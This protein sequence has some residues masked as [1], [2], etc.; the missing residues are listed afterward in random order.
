M[1]L[2]PGDVRFFTPDE[3]ETTKALAGI[4][5]HEGDVLKVLELARA[6]GYTVPRLRIMGI[7]PA[8]LE[9]RRGPVADPRGPDGRL[10]GSGD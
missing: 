5:T 2:A 6:A 1:G 9:R 10:R 8:T 7:E 4:S 3:V